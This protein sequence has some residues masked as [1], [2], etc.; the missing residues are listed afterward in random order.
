MRDYFEIEY[1]RLRNVKQRNMEID[2]Q[3]NDIFEKI[4]QAQILQHKKETEAQNAEKT[5][6]SENFKKIEKIEKLGNSI[7]SNESGK[8][9]NLQNFNVKIADA[10]SE[11]YLNLNSYTIL[12]EKISAEKSFLKNKEPQNYRDFVKNIKKRVSQV[13][14]DKYLMM[15]IVKDMEKSFSFVFVEIF[16]KI[17]L[18]Q[19]KLQIANHSESAVFYAEFTAIIIKLYTSKFEKKNYEDFSESTFLIFL[20]NHIFEK[21]CSETTLKAVYK[22]YFEILQGMRLYK[23]AWCFLAGILNSENVDIKTLFLIESFFSTLNVTVYKK[24]ING[25]I[26]YINSYIFDFAEKNT[27]KE[28]ISKVKGLKIRIKKIFNNIKV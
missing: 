17:L 9:N 10:F 13:S 1:E 8:K 26:D 21:E 27:Q 3:K 6:L 2:R 11:N 19:A 4:R 5:K 28:S 20:R 15:K 7:S 18:E 25:V 12:K 16:S 23:E 14:S 22:L 24:N